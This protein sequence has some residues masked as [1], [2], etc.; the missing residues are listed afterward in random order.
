M[1]TKLCSRDVSTLHDIVKT[2]Q[3]CGFLCSV[4]VIR[5]RMFS[6]QNNGRFHLHERFYIQNCNISLAHMAAFMEHIYKVDSIQFSVS[7]WK[8]GIEPSTVWSVDNHLYHSL[9]HS[10]LKVKVAIL[11]FCCVMFERSNTPKD[12]V[13]IVQISFQCQCHRTRSL[14]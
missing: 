9:S 11:F 1:K 10:F 12:I 5:Q 7:P 2:R 3:T 14:L 8:P 4:M 13:G 6:N